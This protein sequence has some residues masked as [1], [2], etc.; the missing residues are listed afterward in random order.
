MD[1]TQELNAP[2][3]RNDINTTHAVMS[4]IDSRYP[5]EFGEIH[6]RA[7]VQEALRSN[8]AMVGCRI[9]D[10][11]AATL[12]RVRERFVAERNLRASL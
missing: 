7:C 12:R 3:V 2:Y 4:H 8:D 5:G 9:A 11:I 6:Y 1:A 10:N